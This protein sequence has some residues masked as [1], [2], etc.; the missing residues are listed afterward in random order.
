MQAA[1]RL[2]RHACRSLLL[3][4]AL[5]ATLPAAAAPPMGC[6]IEAERIADVGSPV[7]GIVDRIAVERGQRVVRGQVLAVLRDSVERATLTMVTSR[8]NSSAEFQAA[9]SNAKFARERLQRADDLFRQKFISQQALDQARA[10]ADLA[11]QKLIQAGEQRQVVGQERDVAA[12]QLAQRVIRSPIDGV[13]SERFMSAGERVDDKPLLRI[14]K[15][16]PLRVQLV[17]PVAM[18]SQF[19][20][21]A[22]ATVWPELPGFAAVG[23]RVTMIDR[24]FD[25]ASNTFRVHLELPNRD[26]ALPAGLR[27]RAELTAAAPA[28]AARPASPPPAAAVLPVEAAVGKALRRPAGEG[29]PARRSL[30][31]KARAG[32]DGGT[33]AATGRIVAQHVDEPRGN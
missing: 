21:G 5:A 1:F 27:C 15:I 8:A 16:D 3:P 28:P 11:E 20:P 7:V 9:V 30:D 33:G 26:G 10:E 22:A 32:I 6:L 29:G 18:Y 4:I 14:A 12:A 13:V 31:G 25:A 19:Q 24:V 2:H 17:V 23:A